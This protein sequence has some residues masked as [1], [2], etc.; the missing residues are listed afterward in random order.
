MDLDEKKQL[1]AGLGV[2][3]YWVIDIRG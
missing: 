1:Y 2:P 3:E